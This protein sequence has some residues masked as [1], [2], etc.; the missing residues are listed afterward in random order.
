[1]AELPR[2]ELSWGT[3][4]PDCATRQTPL[5]PPL[6]P[7]GD[8][9]DWQ[10]RDYDGFRRRMLEEV[11]ARFP[12]R[13]RW[14]PADFEVMLIEILATVLD[15][16]SDMLDRVGTEAFLETAR[17]PES[18]RRLLAF[19]GY[20]AVSRAVADGDLPPGSGP[21]DLESFW[22][23]QPLAMERARRAGPP[24]LHLQY[25]MVTAEDHARRL[26][27]HPLVLR[28]KASSQWTGSWN[29]LRLAVVGWN[30][31]SLDQDLGDLEESLRRRVERFA[32]ERGLPGGTLDSRTLGAPPSDRPTSLRTLLED[33]VEAYRMVG[34]E[35]VLEDAHRVGVALALS[36][37][38]A[39]GFFHSQVRRALVET[40]GPSPG[41]FF[42]PGR[43]RFGEDLKASDII[44]AAMALDGVESICLRR[45]KRLGSRYPDCST[46]GTLEL[47]PL[48]VALCDNDPARPERG[49]LRLKLYGGLRG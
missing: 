25:R 42:E 5:P 49:T 38:V 19:I 41:G 31:R 35:V 40:L 34:Q 26:E 33:Y 12:E 30:D 14:N 9:F 39:D 4:C 1:M 2:P 20:D 7:V 32:L 18:V 8:D 36:V 27:D 43:L 11:A 28:A 47:G 6:P 44:Q 17:R 24:A 13:R 45:F 48:E 22:S 10:T 3:R 37:V 46:T 16:L 21:H 23:R 15:Q 29:T